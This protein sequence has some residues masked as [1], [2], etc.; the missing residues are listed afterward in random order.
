M[1]RPHLA[2]SMM[3]EQPW[4]QAALPLLEGGLID[5]LEWSFDCCWDGGEV[6]VWAVELL[7]HFQAE[8]RLYGHGV[9]YSILTVDGPHHREWLE[10]FRSECATRHY[11][12]ITE[13]FGLMRTNNFHRGAPLP[14]PYD[15]KL[16]ALAGERLRELRGI[17][18]C[19]VGIENLAL[20]FT[21][22]D[23]RDHARVIGEILAPA[24]GFY[25][26]DLHNLYCQSVNFGIPLAELFQRY[27]AAQICELHISG[28]S[29]SESSVG[30][31]ERR[32]RRDTHDDAV[33]E[34]LFE[35]LP[36][37]LPQLPALRVVTFE[38][39]S[40]GLEGAAAQQQFVADAARL[41]EI[42][43]QSF[44]EAPSDAGA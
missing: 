28:G 32:V 31:A 29:W 10:K 37:I 8:R 25:L 30:G 3:P 13:H 42:L 6:P 41:R 35:L 33:P 27:P 24:D 44:P 43:D 39:L 26:V 16:T 7:D 4:L 2:L 19:P 40:A 17:A 34:A 15:T 18:G 5:A 14:V 36:Q 12:H 11:Q 38:Q 22:Q 1:S 20:A 23:V 9:T 21:A